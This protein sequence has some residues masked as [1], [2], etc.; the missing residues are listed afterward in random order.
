MKINTFLQK[1]F[2][3]FFLVALVVSCSSDDSDNSVNFDAGVVSHA[4]VKE[5]TFPTNSINE[6]I[7]DG[8]INGTPIKLVKSGDSSLSFYMPNDIPTGN[9][10][11]LIPSLNATI[12]VEV[13][14]TVLTVSAD[15]TMSDFFTNL[16]TYSQTLDSSTPEGLDMSQAI[17]SFVNFYNNSNQEQKDAFAIIYQANKI[18]FNNFLLNV[19]AGRNSQSTFTDFFV[20]NKKAVFSIALGVGIV[21]AAPVLG[22]ATAVAAGV[23]GVLLAKKGCESAYRANKDLIDNVYNDITV[24]VNGFFGLNNRANENIVLVDNIAKQL[25]FEV[26]RRKIIASDESKTT[27]LAI[28]YFESY[29]MYNEFAGETNL[30]IQNL[31]T[32]STIDYSEVALET[33]PTSSPEIVTNVT[34]DIFTNVSFSVN[35]SNL[36]LQQSTLQSDGQLNVKVSLVGNPTSNSISSNL[37]YSY[38]NGFSDFSGKLSLRVDRSLEGTWV[39]ESYGGIPVGQFENYSNLDCPNIVVG[40]STVLNETLIFGTNTFTG[41]S[42]YK[43]IS[44]NLTYNPTT[45]AVTNDGPDTEIIDNNSYNGTYT[46]NPSNIQII[47]NSGVGG[48]DTI[49]FLSNNRIK[50]VGEEEIYVRQ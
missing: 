17:T 8:S 16:S 21:V 15:E 50:T 40:K 45:C 49:I 20:N 7:Y 31:N 48:S 9:Y 26:S 34:S 28:D 38:S 10:D 35:N 5:L 42:S 30:N 11:L 46:V 41:S 3:L 36:A 25:T 2:A 22:G 33:L 23:L 39:L 12:A 37:N 47:Y 13:N 19:D 18:K 32:S 43:N 27:P 24:K 4:Q 6:N 14:Q 44:F 29:R 1:S